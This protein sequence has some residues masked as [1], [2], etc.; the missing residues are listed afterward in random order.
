MTQADID[1]LFL[2]ARIGNDAQLQYV[3]SLIEKHMPIYNVCI[4]KRLSGIQ[5]RKWEVVALDTNDFKSVEQ[6][7]VINDIFLATYRWMDGF[8]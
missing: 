5:E 3:Y 2:Q 6:A 8:T 1:N 7:K 4:K